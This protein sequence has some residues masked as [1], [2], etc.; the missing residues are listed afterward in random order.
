MEAQSSDIDGT[1]SIAGNSLIGYLRF[2][3]S[4]GSLPLL[5]LGV[6]KLVILRAV[7]IISITA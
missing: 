1:S 2:Y 5:Q 7:Q 6:T 3:F 4:L